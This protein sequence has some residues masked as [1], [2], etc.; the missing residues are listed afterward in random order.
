M[1]TN[2]TYGRIN[3]Y[4]F[5]QQDV[6]YGGLGLTISEN[7]VVGHGQDGERIVTEELSRGYLGGSLGTCS[8]I[9]AELMHMELLNKK[10]IPSQNCI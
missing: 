9:A 10:K 4:G 6:G 3:S 2:G 7:S 8:E 1:L 5:D